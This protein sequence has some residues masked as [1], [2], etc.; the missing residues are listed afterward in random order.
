MEILVNHPD[1]DIQRF[2]EKLARA[3]SEAVKWEQRKLLWILEEQHQ[4][5][6]EKVFEAKQDAA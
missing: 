4:R 2:A 1:F 3:G 5:E 6:T